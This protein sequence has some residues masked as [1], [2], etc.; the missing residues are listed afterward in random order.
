MPLIQK[1]GKTVQNNQ[2]ML[3]WVISDYVNLRGER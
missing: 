1:P 3:Q 2:D